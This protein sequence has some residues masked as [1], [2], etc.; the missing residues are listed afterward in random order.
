MDK[1]KAKNK[2]K[3][4]R[5]NRTRAKIIGTAKQPRLSVFRSLKYSSAQLIDDSAGRTLISVYEK[6]LGEIKTKESGPKGKI[7]A[8]YQVGLLLAKKAI[9]SRI[10]MAVFDRGAYKYHGRVEALARGAR[11]GGLRF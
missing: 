2:R 6:E 8:A 11:K 5:Q 4:R 3:I 7:S 9:A 10:K 1:N